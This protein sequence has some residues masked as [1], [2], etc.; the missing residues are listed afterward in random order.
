MS[1]DDATLWSGTLLEILYAALKSG[2]SDD[3]VK[4]VLK[5]LGAKG[6]KRDYLAEQVEERLGAQAAVRVKRLM[7]A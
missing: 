4:E 2:K 3:A 1:D 5:D 6:F 7:A